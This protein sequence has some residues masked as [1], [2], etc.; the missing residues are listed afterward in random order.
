MHFKEFRCYCLRESLS[1]CDG[2][3]DISPCTAGVALGISL[4]HF[5]GNINLQRKFIGLKPNESIHRGYFEI[6]PNTG[7]SLNVYVP[8]QINI[9]IDPSLPGFGSARK[10]LIPV[11]WTTQESG[12][13]D[14]DVLALRILV[15]F[16]D[17]GNSMA[18][19]SF[20][21]LSLWMFYLSKR[22]NSDAQID[23]NESH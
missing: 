15:M 3:S 18:A 23:R 12:P 5:L 9:H 6:E 11:L 16:I 20:F 10:G 2:W 22:N 19:I 13:N 21:T 1:E 7:I 17:Y 8:V 14:S 4:P